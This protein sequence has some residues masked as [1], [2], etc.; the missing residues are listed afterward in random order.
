MEESLWIDGAGRP[1][2]SWQMIVIG[3]APAGG[4]SVSWALRRRG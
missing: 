2:A 3:E 4:A 1:R